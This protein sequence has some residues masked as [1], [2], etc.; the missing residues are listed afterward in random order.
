MHVGK[1]VNHFKNLLLFW[2]FGLYIQEQKAAECRGR[3]VQMKKVKKSQK[4]NSS[5]KKP[6]Q[7]AYNTESFN[8]LKNLVQRGRADWLDYKLECLPCCFGEET[9]RAF[10]AMAKLESHCKSASHSAYME[11]LYRNKE[12]QKLYTELQGRVYRGN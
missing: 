10:N 4:K 7:V 9:Y 1:S 11:E 5:K 8:Y 6:N 12:W 2:L 3:R